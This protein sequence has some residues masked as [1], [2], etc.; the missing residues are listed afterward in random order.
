MYCC[1]YKTLYN[2]ISSNLVQDCSPALRGFS[3]YIICPNIVTLATG[4]NLV[5]TGFAFCACTASSA[6]LV[7]VIIIRL[8][9]TKK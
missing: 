9:R 4:K 2:T 8:R 1:M 6:E 3:V 7:S 5:Y